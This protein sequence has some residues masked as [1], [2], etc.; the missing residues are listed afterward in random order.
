MRGRSMRE[1]REIHD[2][3]VGDGNTGRIG[4]AGGRTPMVNGSRKSDRSEVP[5]K[6]PNNAGRLHHRTTAAEGVEGRDLAEGNANELTTPRTQSRTRVPSVLARVRQAAQRNKDVKFTALL[7]HVTVDR[8]RTAFMEV[9]RKAAPG[10]DGVTW[11]AYHAY[12]EEHLQALHG[13]LHRGAYRSKPTRRAYIPKTDGRLRP[14]GVAALEDKIV[15]R[16]VVEVMQAIYEADFLGFS[17]GFRPGRKPH[18]SL[19]AL[20]V[21]LT[22]TKVNWVLDADI[23]GFFDTIN[24]E[25]L[26][27][28]VQH[29]MAD[30]RV[31]RLIRNWLSAG[32]MEDGAWAATEV[33]TPQGA[34]VSPLLANLYLHY[35]FDLWVQQWRRKHVRGDMILT[36][37]ADDFIVG[38]EYRTD[39]EQFLEQLRERFRKFGLELHPEKTRLI[40]FGRK[41]VERR[42]ARGLGK[43]ETFTYLGLTHICGRS[44]KGKFL[45]HR[46]TMRTRM[47]AKL[48]EVKTELTRRRHDPIPD[49]GAWLAGVVRGY[50]AYHAVPTNMRVMAQFRTQVVR[51]WHRALRRRGQRDRTDWARMNRLATRW[52]PLARQQHPFPNVRFDGR[53]RSKSPVR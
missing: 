34:T 43:P 46:H 37:W 16:A 41:A 7:H 17:Y 44:S 32:V 49:Q 18:D 2:P 5:T 52:L 27:R 25:W 10:I 39:A 31:L 11:E 8:L 12:L 20:A 6:P 9:K 13:R 1:N 19:D 50:F 40:E 4:K 45:L 48:R 38:F 35:V 42:R 53:T 15:Q 26:L 29:R 23:R 28:F 24:H 21:G 30:Q 22:R 33:G 36:R 47:Q 3:S 14:L 51:H